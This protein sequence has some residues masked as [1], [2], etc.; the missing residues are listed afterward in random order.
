MSNESIKRRIAALELPAC[1]DTTPRSLESFY[2]LPDAPPSG[3]PQPRTLAEFY[4]LT[5]PRLVLPDSER[6]E[7]LAKIEAAI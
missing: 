7:V 1:T 6:D 3:K 4:S 5:D 2:G